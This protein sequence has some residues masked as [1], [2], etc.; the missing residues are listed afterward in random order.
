MVAATARA[1]P[2]SARSALPFR[3]LPRPDFSLKPSARFSS[4]SSF[5]WARN[6][7]A[8]LGAQ[9]LA[10]FLGAEPNASREASLQHALLSCVYPETPWAQDVCS[11]V[12][13]AGCRISG[14]RSLSPSPCTPLS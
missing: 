10:A 3:G 6:L 8:D 11:L 2:S 9:G 4:S 12:R 5:E 13:A 1:P 14:T 7:R